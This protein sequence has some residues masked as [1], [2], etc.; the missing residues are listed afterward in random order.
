M[1]SQSRIVAAFRRA[2]VP[3]AAYYAVTLALPLANGAAQS[4]AR[5]AAHASL[6]L[7]VPPVAIVLACGL[8]AIGRSVSGWFV[9]AAFSVEAGVAFTAL[10]RSIV[11]LTSARTR[12]QRPRRCPLTP[13]EAE[14][15]EADPF[16]G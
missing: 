4:G 10:R 5:F 9:R 1:S 13:S 12:R 8:Y 15:L 6:V 3:L 11:V 16:F 2:A 7:V 14:S